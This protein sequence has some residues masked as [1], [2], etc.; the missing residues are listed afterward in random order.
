MRERDVLTTRRTQ[1]GPISRAVRKLIS[2]EERVFLSAENVKAQ[3][4]TTYDTY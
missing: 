4:R 3:E 1:I 2:G